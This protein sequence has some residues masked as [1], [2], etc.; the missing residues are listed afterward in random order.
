MHIVKL[1]ERRFPKRK[2][3]IGTILVLSSIIL[4]LLG[5]GLVLIQ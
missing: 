1:L 4:L 2:G 3:S 5:L